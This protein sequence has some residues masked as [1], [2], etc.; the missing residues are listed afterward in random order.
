[1]LSHMPTQ[2]TKTDIYI[3]SKSVAVFCEVE[4]KAFLLLTTGEWIH[5][6]FYN[7]LYFKIAYLVLEVNQQS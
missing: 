6:S 5:S 7:D 3:C 4:N 2:I 1:M